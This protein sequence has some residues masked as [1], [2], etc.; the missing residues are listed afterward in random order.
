MCF[1]RPVI[2]EVFEILVDVKGPC[3]CLLNLLLNYSSHCLQ[4]S[5]YGNHKPAVLDEDIAKK[6]FLSPI[7]RIPRIMILK[8]NDKS[9]YFCS[10][11]RH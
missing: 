8:T 3:L 7:K 6:R 2:V 1:H 11:Y 4:N 9:M 5:F 10:Y